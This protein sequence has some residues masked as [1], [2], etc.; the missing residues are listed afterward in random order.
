MDPKPPSLASVVAWGEVSQHTEFEEILVKS[1]R[2]MPHH[3]H[4]DYPL[5]ISC[6]Q[7]SEYIYGHGTRRTTRFPAKHTPSQPELASSTPDP[8]NKT[9]IPR[10][11]F[12]SHIFTRIIQQKCL[13]QVTILES[14]HG[15]KSL[16]VSQL[17]HR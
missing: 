7:D 3:R 13:I 2:E 11:I 15:K 8:Q 16:K 6:N 4:P 1:I 17:S 14:Q 12:L 9:R 5:G 10:L